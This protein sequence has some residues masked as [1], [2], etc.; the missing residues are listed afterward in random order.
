MSWAPQSP[1]KRRVPLADEA[2][3]GTYHLRAV[4][5]EGNTAELAIHVDR[6]VL[7]KFKVAVEPTG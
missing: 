2:N 1:Q 7:P 6:Y 3:L 5:N 4:M